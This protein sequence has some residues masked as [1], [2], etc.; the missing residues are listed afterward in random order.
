MFPISF[1]FYYCTVLLVLQRFKERQPVEMAH[2]HADI[3]DNAEC[4]L[5]IQVT[6]APIGCCFFLKKVGLPGLGCC[7]TQ[8]KGRTR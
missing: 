4:V 7:T 1:I 2:T 6:G 5:K 3:A 8:Q